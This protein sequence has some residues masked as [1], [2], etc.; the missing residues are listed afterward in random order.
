ME[1]Q[2]KDSLEHLISLR[3][4]K[5]IRDND[6]KRLKDAVKNKKYN[7]YNWSDSVKSE[8]VLGKLRVFKLDKYLAFHGLSKNG[9]KGDKV[10]RMMAHCILSKDQSAQTRVAP[11]SEAKFETEYHDTEDEEKTISHDD[12][13]CDESDADDEVIVVMSGDDSETVSDVEN[14]EQNIDDLSDE[15][16]NIVWEQ[17]CNLIENKTRSGRI[18]RPRRYDDIWTYL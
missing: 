17:A 13:S 5:A 12:Y 9:K 2:V 6:R 10:S 18:A 4:T 7:D 16:N 3:R 1:Y 11:D 15:E 8:E 14:E